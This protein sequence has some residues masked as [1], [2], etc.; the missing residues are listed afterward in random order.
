MVLLPYHVLI[1]LPIRVCR[2]VAAAGVY[3][4]DSLAQACSW[5]WDCM[6][7]VITGAVGVPWLLLG[8]F[9]STDDAQDTDVMG[10]DSALYYSHSYATG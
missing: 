2:G 10:T 7:A 1:T 5:L 9:S 6:W 4:W 3:V 8:L